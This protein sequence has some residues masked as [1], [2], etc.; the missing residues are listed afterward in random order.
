VAIVAPDVFLTGEYNDGE[1]APTYAKI[2]A[3]YAGYTFGYNR[4]ILGNRVHD[5]LTTIAYVQQYPQ[6]DTIHLAGMRSS[7]PIVILA[8]ALAGDAVTRTLA[9]LDGFD[10]DQVYSVTDP[11]FLPGALKYGGMGAFW[12]CA[13]RTR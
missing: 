10:F 7:G 3:G 6:T 12:R 4:T 2:D 5:I 13:S 11:M 8:K 1:T 9:D